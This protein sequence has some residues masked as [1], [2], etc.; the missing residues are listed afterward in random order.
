VPCSSPGTATDLQH[1]RRSGQGRSRG[2]WPAGPA[3]TAT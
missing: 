3:A 2:G 1:A